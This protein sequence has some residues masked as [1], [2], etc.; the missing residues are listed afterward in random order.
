MSKK[1]GQLSVPHPGLSSDTL[2]LLSAPL[3]THC[4]IPPSPKLHRPRNRCEHVEVVRALEVKCWNR[5]WLVEH[6]N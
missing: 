5:I 4:P 2:R 1:H 6:P 3:R